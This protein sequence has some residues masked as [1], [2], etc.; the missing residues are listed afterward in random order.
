M[1]GL[2][3]AGACGHRRCGCGPIPYPRAEPRPQQFFA[4]TPDTTASSLPPPGT[5]VHPI[6]PDKPCPALPGTHPSKCYLGKRDTG[7]VGTFYLLDHQWFS[8]A[9]PQTSLQTLLGSR[10][11]EVLWGEGEQSSTM[12]MVQAALHPKSAPSASP[13]PPS[14]SPPLRKARDMDPQ[15]I[16]HEGIPNPGTCHAAGLQFWEG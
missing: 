12:G 5:P 9:L 3:A 7:L 2:R 8:P 14:T 6:T 15:T 13:I 16:N 1:V 11:V 10:P 4:P